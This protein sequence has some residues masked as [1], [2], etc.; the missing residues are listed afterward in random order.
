[1]CKCGHDKKQHID[2]RCYYYNTCFCSRYRSTEKIKKT[3]EELAKIK[4]ERQH[5]SVREH[6]L[7][8]KACREYF[9]LSEKAV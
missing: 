3:A 5:R 9:G 2:G 1:M 7:C 4:M 8:C 6:M